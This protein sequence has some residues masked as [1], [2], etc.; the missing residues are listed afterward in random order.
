MTTNKWSI[1]PV[2]VAAIAINI[3]ALAL[4]VAWSGNETR[5]FTLLHEDGIVE[6]MQFLCFTVIA[7]MLAYVAIDRATRLPR[8]TLAV[9]GIAGISLVV[10]LAAME[11]ISW[12]QRVLNVPSPDFFAVNN[13]QAEMNLHNLALG[14]G[15]I[16]K[17]ILLKLIVLIG[18]VHNVVLP[19]LA[20]SRPGI[21]RFVESLGL[22]LP[23]LT[24]SFAYILLV[25][26]SNVLIDHPRKGELG[27]LFGATHYLSTAFAA[28][29]IGSN[30]DS[31]ALI[32][33]EVDARKVTVL[34]IMVMA[35]LV[36]MAWMLTSV[37]R[38]GAV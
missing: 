12:F 11:E 22:Y 34:F 4:A 20:R 36:L 21:R 24:A 1:H 3:C 6:W 28:Y 13:R 23:P 5:M 16:H 33:H 15:S 8:S 14:K 7:A 35:F 17:T 2:I 19:L 25:I 10:A 9:L 37:S 32:E 31:P 29:V 26:L 27:E 18:L 38:M 30:Y